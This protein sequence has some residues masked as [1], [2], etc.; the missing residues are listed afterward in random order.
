ME[1]ILKCKKDLNEKLEKK[2]K[3]KKEEV[4]VENPFFS[5]AK[6]E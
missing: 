5:T 1:E 2:E 4:K 6:S 3:K